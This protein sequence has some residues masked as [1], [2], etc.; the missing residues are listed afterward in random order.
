MDIDLLLV[1]CGKKAII[2]EVCVSVLVFCKIY[3]YRNERLE[4]QP[5]YNY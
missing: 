4:M 1:V 5:Q 3:I 2:V